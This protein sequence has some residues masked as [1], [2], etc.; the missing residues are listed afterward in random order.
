M[1]IF[2]KFFTSSTKTANNKIVIL[3]TI[4]RIIVV[5]NLVNEIMFTQRWGDIFTLILTLALFK[6]PQFT[7]RLFNIEI[8][9]LLELIIILFI[10]SSTILGELGDFYGYFKLWDTILHTINGFLASGVGFSLIYLLN[11]NTKGMNLNPLFLAIV[12]FCFSMT[13]GVLWELIE[14]SA[15]RWIDI[16]MQKDRIIQEVNSVSIGEEKI[17]FIIL[18]ILKK[19]LSKAKMSLVIILKL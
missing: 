13:I 15:D 3:Y 12:T 19:P 10:F 9:N 4:F 1:H 11:K 6:I 2:K 16:D 17:L 18:K 7:E 8:P 5:F 14:Y